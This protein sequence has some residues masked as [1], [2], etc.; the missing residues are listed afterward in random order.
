M[1]P[2][3]VYPKSLLPRSSFKTDVSPQDVEDDTLP[4]F[5]FYAMSSEPLKILISGAGIAGSSLALMLVRQPSFITRPIVTL[6]ERSP[7]PRLTGQA[8]DIRGTGVKVIRKLGLEEKIKARHTTETG[9]AFVNNKGAKIG[10]FDASGDPEKQ[11]ATS[12]F[13]ILRGE[14]AELILDDLNTSEG[15]GN[16]NIVYDER[17]ESMIEQEDGVAV[18]F[19]GG[20]LEAQKFDVVVSADGM[21]STTRPM[22][23]PETGTQDCIKPLG[24]YMAYFTVPRME[25]DDNLWLWHNEPGGLAVHVRPHRSKKTMG[26]YLSMCKWKHER[27]PEIDEVISKGVDAQKRYLHEQFAGAAWETERFLSAMDI[28]DDFYMQQ[29]ARVDTA[30]WTRSRCALLGDSAHCTMGVGTSYAITGAYVLAGELAQMRSNGPEE[31]AAAL[32][33]Y[34]EVHRSLVGEPKM[35]PGFPQLANPQ[36]GLAVAVLQSIIKLVYWTQLHKLIPNAVQ[37]NAEKWNMPDYGW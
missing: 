9:I 33:R 2:S 12:E 13:E 11:S 16:V 7:V 36:T 8:I 24:W 1:W 17:I 26:V 32:R 30:K 28:S 35:P 21:S 37:E 22:M 31:I 23:F 20:K 15:R 6:I 10:Q 14:L 18:T 19:S 29:V 25:H 27:D 4:Q 5:T 3:L 34:E